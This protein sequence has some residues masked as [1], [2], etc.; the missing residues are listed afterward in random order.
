MLENATHEDE[1]GLWGASKVHLKKAPCH[2][3]QPFVGLSQSGCVRQVY[4]N[5]AFVR[6]AASR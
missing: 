4:A 6:I 5:I 2:L 1:L 3:D